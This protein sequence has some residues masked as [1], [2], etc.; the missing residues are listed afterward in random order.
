MPLRT[1]NQCLNPGGVERQLS[2]VCKIYFASFFCV[3][4]RFRRTYPSSSSTIY[5]SK[6]HLSHS[7]MVALCLCTFAGSRRSWFLCL[8]ILVI[9]QAFWPNFSSRTCLVITIRT[10]NIVGTR[11]YTLVLIWC[12]CHIECHHKMLT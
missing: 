5:N 12:V 11:N 8:L 1:I 3:S 9:P 2:L 7:C 4:Q 10:Y 6:H